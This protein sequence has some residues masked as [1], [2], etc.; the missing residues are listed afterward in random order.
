MWDPQLFQLCSWRH[1]TAHAIKQRDAPFRRDAC[2]HIADRSAN[3][4][5]RGT[6]ALTFSSSS[7][8]GSSGAQTEASSGSRHRE[9]I[10]TKM[11]SQDN[12]G[13]LPRSSAPSISITVSSR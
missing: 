10:Q 2:L 8:A 9:N 13:M 11:H 7:Q 3:Q 6:K 4:A 5:T 1:L 12:T